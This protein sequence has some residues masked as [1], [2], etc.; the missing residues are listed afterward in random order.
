MTSVLQVS[1]SFLKVKL[2]REGLALHRFLLSPSIHCSQAYPDEQE[3][4]AMICFWMQKV[5]AGRV[6]ERQTGHVIKCH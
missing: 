1:G 6:E 2:P 5:R 4:T 3:H